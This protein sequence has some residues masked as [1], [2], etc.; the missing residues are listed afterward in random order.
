M[1][2][3]WRTGADFEA[4]RLEVPPVSYTA[5]GG[6][7]LWDHRRRIRFGRFTPVPA[8][9]IAMEAEEPV[10]STSVPV[11]DRINRSLSD[12]E[13][14][15]QAD[16]DVAA[17][18]SPDNVDAP[19]SPLEDPVPVVDGGADGPEESIEEDPLEDTL[20]EE[21]VVGKPEDTDAK[22]WLDADIVDWATHDV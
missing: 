9:N 21:S 2:F 15:K 12:L 11:P 18:V 14:P 16:N 17:P 5:A 4:G 20:P 13:E 1:S 3:G 10:L 8:P 6:M 19:M 22:A 7:L